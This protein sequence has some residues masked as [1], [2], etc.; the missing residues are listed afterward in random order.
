MS[1]GIR[2]KDPKAQNNDECTNQHDLFRKSECH[3]Q[4]C[5]ACRNINS[6]LSLWQ[7][8]YINWNVPHSRFLGPPEHPSTANPN[9]VQKSLHGA[10]HD[11]TPAS[12]HVMSPKSTVQP[13]APDAVASS[14]PSPP[15]HSQVQP[16]NRYVLSQIST[17]NGSKLYPTP[18]TVL[19]LS[20][21]QYASH[22]DGD[23]TE[24]GQDGCCCSCRCFFGVVAVAAVETTTSD[25]I[26]VN[27]TI[28]I[29]IWIG[30]GRARF[31]FCLLVSLYMGYLFVIVFVLW[32]NDF[33]PRVLLVRFVLFAGRCS[34]TR[35]WSYRPNLCVT[36]HY[37]ILLICD[38]TGCQ[39]DTTSDTDSTTYLVVWR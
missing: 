8:P 25:V 2:Q 28:A 36:I 30:K 13:P 5:I 20:P 27:I 38:V 1:L 4:L 33:W 7:N 29:R 10:P 17:A 9:E 15:R 19:P 11:P 12:A 22:V 31:M 3:I 34:K 26:T 21:P 32:V 37:T 39:R 16:P 6:V 23:V 18:P 24:S 35:R 14:S